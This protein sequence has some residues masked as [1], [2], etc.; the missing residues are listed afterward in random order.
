[1]IKH[2]KLNTVYYFFFLFIFLIIVSII[3]KG[4]L[5][6]WYALHIPSLLPPHF[7]LRFYQYPAFAINEGRNPLFSLHEMWIANDAFGPASNFLGIPDYF[8]PAFK[9][10]YFLNFHKELYFLGF[11]VFFIIS[12]V[13][14]VYKILTIKKN[15]FWILI[16][17]FSSSSL[18]VIE[19]TN[20]DI[21]IFCLLYWTA[22]FPNVLGIILNLLAVYVEFWPMAAGIAFIKKKIKILLLIFLSIFLI[23][24]YKDMFGQNMKPVVS[25]YFSWGA[26]STSVSIKRHFGLEINYINIL[27]FLFSLSLITLINKL[28]L[29]KLQFGKQPSDLEERLFLMG[30]SLYV[31]LFILGS[32]VDYKLIFLIFCVPYLSRLKSKISKYFIVISIVLASNWQLMS[33][34]N[35]ASLG[36]LINIMIKCLI[37][38]ILLSLLIKYFINFYKNYGIKKIFF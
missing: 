37:F 38:V 7:D 28:N 30:S 8:L 33:G 22:V 27:I 5:A 16:L 21:I 14:C 11:A 25:D 35:Y 2:I 26:K 12:Y 24:F 29:F 10:A 13:F 9:F 32:N 36:A 18:L 34:N 19:R 23:I 15:S 3:T 17:F 31:G 1:M 20:N 6:T 4:W